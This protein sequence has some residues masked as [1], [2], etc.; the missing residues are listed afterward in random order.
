M[1]SDWP[2]LPL[3]EWEPTYL[4]LHRWTQVLGKIRMALEPPL[5]HWWHVTL[6]VT[7]RGLEAN[8]LPYDR[9]FFSMTLDF[10]EH[11]LSIDS[12]AGRSAGFDLRPMPVAD[13]YQRTLEL[14]KQIDVSVSIYPV[15]SEVSDTTPFHEDYKH[16]EYDREYAGRLHRILLEVD[17][18]FRAERG[19]FLGKSS[20]SHFF[21][22]AFDLAFARYSGRRNPQP[23]GDRVMGEAYSHEEIAHGFWPG[24]DWPVGPTRLDEAVFYAYAVPQPEG[25]SAAPIAPASARY[26]ERFGEFVL[27]YEAVRLSDD[28]AATLTQFIRSTYSQAARLAKWDPALDRQAG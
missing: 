3:S 24:G 23:P 9:R 16:R 10:R 21:W 13:F 2:A 5:N 12:S 15:P 11:R 27:P 4:T 7:A 20:P 6:A 22:G 1:S 14:L 28:P 8:A 19:R 18:V 17:R 25:L 26:D